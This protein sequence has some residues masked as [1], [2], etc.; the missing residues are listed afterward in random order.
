MTEMLDGGIYPPF[1]SSEMLDGG[2]PY[3][4]GH[5]YSGE[6]LD[7]ITHSLD[8]PPEITS[9]CENLAVDTGKCAL[10][11][12][13][14]SLRT[15]PRARSDGSPHPNAGAYGSGICYTRQGDGGL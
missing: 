9:L 14:C 10:S 7:S 13:G 6:T 11:S 4:L 5:P 1:R 3:Q 8:T 15:F 12:L 2:H